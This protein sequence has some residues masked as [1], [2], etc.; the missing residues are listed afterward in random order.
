MN[1]R[2]FLEQYDWKYIVIDEGHRIKNLDCKLVRELKSYR[3]ANRLLLTG[4]PL[5]NNLKELWA[6]LNYLMV[7]HILIDDN[8]SL[9]LLRKLVILWN[10]LIFKV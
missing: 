2:K 9:Q 10:G 4:T 3:S 8:E 1:D 6:L 7:N 5:Q